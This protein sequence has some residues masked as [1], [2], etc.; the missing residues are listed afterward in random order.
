MALTF[1]E[2]E[3]SQTVNLE[4]PF[5]TNDKITFNIVNRTIVQ[6]DYI[7]P[8]IREDANSRKV[9]FQMQKVFDGVDQSDKTITVSYVSPMGEKFPPVLTFGKTITNDAI[10]FHWLI[11]E[12]V[13]RKSGNVAFKV[14]VSDNSG[15]E[16]NTLPA[17]IFVG[18]GI[19]GDEPL[20]PTEDW[21]R[22]WIVQADGYLD[23]LN[24]VNEKVSGIAEL[25]AKNNIKFNDFYKAIGQQGRP[26]L[27]V[28]GSGTITLPKNAARSMMQ[29]KLEGR[30]VEGE[31]SIIAREVSV[32]SD[33][34]TK[35]FCYNEP[36]VLRKHADGT[37]DTRN[38]DGSITK[39]IA[40]DGSILAKPEIIRGIS[41]GFL[42]SYPGGTYYTDYALKNI[43]IYN[44]NASVINPAYPIKELESI[45][46]H[47]AD[48]SFTEI[49]I[50]T[51]YVAADKLSFIDDNLT[52]GDAVSFVYKFNATAP[53]PNVILYPINE[54]DCVQSPTSN[55]WYFIS[56]ALDANDDIIHTKIEI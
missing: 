1:T 26:Y 45:Y 5:D 48:G 6:V 46:K 20:P 52:N 9:H 31:S 15:Y 43:V 32:A 56:H 50:S 2:Y 18:E 11:G 51:A 25:T 53:L 23:Q 24:L 49:D 10:Y 38:A 17:S 13:C 30:T 7:D 28:S 39:R 12:S 40:D 36:C 47:N 33:G 42:V 21:Y 35:T 16:W 22:S 34:I 4:T 14:T 8:L 3:Q 37:C 54:T 55:K 19:D 41:D 29:T 44:N 27:H